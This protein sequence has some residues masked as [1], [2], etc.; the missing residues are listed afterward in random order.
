M[1]GKFK[2]LEKKTHVKNFKGTNH[3]NQRDVNCHEYLQEP[4][5]EAEDNRAVCNKA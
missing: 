4:T 2:S 5:F 3:V 1:K